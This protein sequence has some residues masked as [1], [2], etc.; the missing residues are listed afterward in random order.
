MVMELH[1]E[2]PEPM[3]TKPF[4]KQLRIR[5]LHLEEELSDQLTSLFAGPPKPKSNTV[6][7]EAMIDYFKRKWP[8]RQLPP[9]PPPQPAS[10]PKNERK[11]KKKA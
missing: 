10:L 3:D 4:I 11:T 7:L 5:G 2:N 6:D 1:K 9:T 8:E